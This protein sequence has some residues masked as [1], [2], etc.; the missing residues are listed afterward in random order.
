MSHLGAS[1]F[2]LIMFRFAI[3]E[4]SELRLLEPHDADA[5]L[6]A[7]DANR[8]SSGNGW[9]GWIPRNLP[10]TPVFSSTNPYKNSPGS[11]R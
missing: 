10:M 5:L 6:A 11:S 2:I 1:V 3:D 4:H 9:H 8:D 7:V